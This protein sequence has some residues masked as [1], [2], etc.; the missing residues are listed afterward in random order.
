MH[1]SAR[2]S[3]CTPL[4]CNKPK[5]YW[6]PELSKLRDK[7]SFWRMLWIDLGKPRVGAVISCYKECKR[8]FRRLSR[9]CAN[10]TQRL[11]FQD[12]NRFF[13]KRNMKGFGNK[14]KLI[15]RRRVASSLSA[16]EFSSYYSSIMTDDG[17]DFNSAHSDIAE[18]V[19]RLF[20]SHIK[21]PINTVVSERG[22]NAICQT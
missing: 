4:R 13:E 14:I 1:D 18:K 8:T 20:N 6:C 10:N 16:Q 11:K 9:Q 21:E 15:Q 12:V 22:I 2:E 19:C 5:P 7:K 17:T 3:G